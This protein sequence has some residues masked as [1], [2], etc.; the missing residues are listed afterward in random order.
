MND[1]TYKGEKCET[2]TGVMERIVNEM[3]D[4]YCKWP[5]IYSQ[6]YTDPDMAHECML[7]DKCRDCPLCKL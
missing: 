5:K 3:C 4:D 6:R 1:L 2:I 7:Y